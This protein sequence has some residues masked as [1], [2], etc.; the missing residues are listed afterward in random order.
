M[1][2]NDE[3]WPS[4]EEV[5]LAHEEDEDGFCP[6][7]DCPFSEVVM[8]PHHGEHVEHVADVVR[9]LLRPRPAILMTTFSVDSDGVTTQNLPV[10]KHQRTNWTGPR[11]VR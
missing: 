8:S 1:P 4:V 11:E 7:P 6:N 3:T 9:W 2:W 10:N 5:L